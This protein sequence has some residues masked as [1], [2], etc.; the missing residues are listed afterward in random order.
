MASNVRDNRY[1]IAFLHKAWL[2]VAISQI[3]NP[4]KLVCGLGLGGQRGSSQQEHRISSTMMPWMG[5]FQP[6]TEQTKKAQSSGSKMVFYH[7]KQL[8]MSSVGICTL[9]SLFACFTLYLFNELYAQDFL[10]RLLSILVLNVCFS[11]EDPL[12]LLIYISYLIFSVYLCYVLNY[13]H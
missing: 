3:N 7:T 4:G 1:E 9:Y 8:Y 11:G 10:N 5:S 6:V 12:F 13:S 2:E